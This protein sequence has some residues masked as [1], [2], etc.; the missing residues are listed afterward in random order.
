MFSVVAVDKG[1]V[2]GLCM[3]INNQILRFAQNDTRG[4]VLRVDTYRLPSA[5]VRTTPLAARY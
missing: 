2:F 5:A 1:N 3:G 4:H